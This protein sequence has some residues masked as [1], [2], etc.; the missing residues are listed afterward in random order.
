MYL[1]GVSFSFS[2]KAQYLAGL[3]ARL[4]WM[5]IVLSRRS[6]AHDIIL[7]FFKIFHSTEILVI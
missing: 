6:S 1:Y 4:D 3:Y 5:T 2:D 7:L